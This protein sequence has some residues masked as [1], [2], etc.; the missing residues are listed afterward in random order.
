MFSGDNR[1]INTNDFVEKEN[2]NVRIAYSVKAEEYKQFLL[3]VF[4]SELKDSRENNVM[5]S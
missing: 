2:A 1:G 5:G 4:Q 3:E